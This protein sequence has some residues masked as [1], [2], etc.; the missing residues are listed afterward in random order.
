M[1]DNYR[2]SFVMKGS[3]LRNPFAKHQQIAIDCEG[4]KITIYY[5][6]CFLAFQIHRIVYYWV[7]T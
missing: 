4:I 3:I 7:S 6:L 1:D 2:S 5:L